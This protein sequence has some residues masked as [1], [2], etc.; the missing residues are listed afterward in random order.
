ML[1]VLCIVYYTVLYKRV[2]THVMWIKSEFR[3]LDSSTFCF[4]F[5]E[6]TLQEDC[7][8]FVYEMTVID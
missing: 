8:V 3:S 1:A 2:Q 7:V 5:M 6:C 4:V